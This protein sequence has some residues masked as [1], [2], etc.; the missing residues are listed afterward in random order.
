MQPIPKVLLVDDFHSN[1]EILELYLKKSYENNIVIYKAT[2]GEEAFQLFNNHSI[3][4]VLLDVM[5]PDISGFRLCQEMKLKRK[6]D[7][8]PIVMLTALNDKESLLEGLSSGA[9]DF[10]TKPVNSEELMIR[11]K[12]LLS[13][14]MATKEIARKYDL[15]TQ[16][17]HVARELLNDFMPKYSPVIKNVRFEM[18]YEP[19]SI[20][21]GDFFDIFPINDECY[22]FFISD[23]KGHGAAAAMIVAL[24]KEKLHAFK[25]EWLYPEK[26]MKRLNRIMCQFFKNVRNDYFMTAIYAV[27]N[28]KSKTLNW[29]SAGHPPIGYFR[30]NDFTSLKQV[31]LPLG[32]LEDIDYKTSAISFRM[33]EAFVFYTDGIFELP[34]FNK[35]GHYSSL[36][37]S[38]EDFESAEMLLEKIKENIDSS[39]LKDDVNVVAIYI[40]DKNDKI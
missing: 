27:F 39:K 40:G 3:D 26:V 10:L 8:L 31:G 7:F 16:E 12:N 19:S 34:L 32:I 35:G 6:D 24:I 1:L 37:D 21:G 11:V 9:D 36:E 18:I 13:L 17:M 29:C 4:L 20:L 30:Q 33:N 15:L 38:N 28:F 22:G 23:V 25:S 5:L 2:S 14:R